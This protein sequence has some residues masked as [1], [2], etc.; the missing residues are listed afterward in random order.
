MLERVDDSVFFDL[1]VQ[2]I[3]DPMVR[4]LKT[5][6]RRRLKLGQTRMNSIL[7]QTEI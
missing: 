6:S 3:V 1:P 7:Y 2:F 5:A 4:E